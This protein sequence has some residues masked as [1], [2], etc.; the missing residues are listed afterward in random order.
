MLLPDHVDALA[1]QGIVTLADL[2][3]KADDET[4]LE[5]LVAAVGMKRAEGKRLARELR[6]L[7]EFDVE[8]ERLGLPLGTTEAEVRAAN[9]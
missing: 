9:H 1:Q 2:K 5:A 6:R 4:S 7:R 8:L 3:F